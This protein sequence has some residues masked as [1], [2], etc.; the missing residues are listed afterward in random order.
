MLLMSTNLTILLSVILLSLSNFSI[1]RT[2]CME[3]LL[4]MKFI[5]TH[6]QGQLDASCLV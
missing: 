2:H 6:T 5:K 4:S 3:I 1:A